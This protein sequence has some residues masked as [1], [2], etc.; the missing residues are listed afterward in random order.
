MVEA[1]G[2]V[3]LTSRILWAAEARGEKLEGRATGHTVLPCRQL[4]RHNAPEGELPRRVVHGL[5]PAE[6]VGGLPQRAASVP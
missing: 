5:P 3:R 1:M 2:L 6:V 4:S